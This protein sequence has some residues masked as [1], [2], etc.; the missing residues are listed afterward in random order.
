LKVVTPSHCVVSSLKKAVYGIPCREKVKSRH[1]IQPCCGDV[2]EDIVLT[3]SVLQTLCPSN[4]ILTNAALP[5]DETVDAR[6]QEVGKSYVKAA[7][8]ALG[9][10]KGILIVKDARHKLV[11]G[12]LD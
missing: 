2:A 6:I 3:K 5:P 11:G 7:N 9:P 4:L 8:S 10:S 1:L 12:S